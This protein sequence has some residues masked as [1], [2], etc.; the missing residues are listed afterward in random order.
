MSANALKERRH[1][2]RFEVPGAQ[3]LYKS[4]KAFNIFERYSGPVPLKDITKNGACI[5][6]DQQVERGTLVNI[7]IRIPGQEK[8]KVKGH[9]VWN[10][11]PKDPSYAGVQ[12]LPYGEGKKY[13]SFNCRQQLEY[14]TEQYLGAKN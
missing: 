5:L 9:V 6:I 13:N 7:E 11:Y 14:L 1:L 2:E 4:G 8:I 12:F 10:S 3:I